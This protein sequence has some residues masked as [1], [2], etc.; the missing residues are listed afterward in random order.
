MKATAKTK[1]VE[2]ENSGAKASE[3]IQISLLDPAKVTSI[4]YSIPFR[5][6][7]RDKQKRADIFK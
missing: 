6:T 7:K 1:E 5:I 2:E 4:Q 3:S